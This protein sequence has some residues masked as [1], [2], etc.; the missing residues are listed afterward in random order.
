MDKPA[1]PKIEMPIAAP[2]PPPEERPALDIIAAFRDDAVSESKPSVEDEPAPKVEPALGS[3]PLETAEPKPEAAPEPDSE[4][5]A[6]D[7]PAPARPAAP[8]SAATIREAVS[9]EVKQI[10]QEEAEQELRAR[11]SEQ[12]SVETTPAPDVGAAPAPDEDD[13]A[14]RIQDLSDEVNAAQE[15]EAQSTPIQADVS[16]KELVAKA[17]AVEPAVQEKDLRSRDILPDIEEINSTL[18]A[19]DTPEESGIDLSP[20]EDVPVA[21]GGG[22]RRGFRRTLLLAI[23]LVGIYFLAPFVAGRFPQTQGF[24]DGYV[25]V[26]DTVRVLLE[27]AMQSA[28]EAMRGL[29]ETASES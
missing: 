14:A 17:P 26:G 4:S 20:T 5:A 16:P 10:L 23:I 13:L 7:I 11:E 19:P 6:D 29:M 8:T 28:I 22:F 12:K 25:A 9:D 3:E 2:P 1:E 21:K 27:S 18:D 24:M 15:E